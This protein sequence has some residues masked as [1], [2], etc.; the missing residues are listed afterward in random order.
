MSEKYVKSINNRPAF[1][2]DYSWFCF[3]ISLFQWFWCH[4]NN[5]TDQHCVYYDLT[6]SSITI[7][8]S[9]KQH[10][11]SPKHRH[12]VLKTEWS[13]PFVQLWGVCLPLHTKQQVSGT[14]TGEEQV[15][16]WH[17][18]R[19]QKMFPFWGNKKKREARFLTLFIMSKNVHRSPRGV[20]TLRIS[21]GFSLSLSVSHGTTPTESKQHRSH[22]VF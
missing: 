2:N 19:A 1:Q 11:L 3:M 17:V 4:K 20:C 18:F 7:C 22:S 21:A 10:V 9:V 14:E 12:R 6:F 13:N 8:T 5:C 16:G 15:I